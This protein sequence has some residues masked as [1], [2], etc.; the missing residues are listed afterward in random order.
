MADLVSGNVMSVKGDLTKPDPYLLAHGIVFI[1]AFSI[2]M[3]VTSYLIL[4]DRERYYVTHNVVGIII[5]VL[6]VIGWGL[7]TGA[8]KGREA[9]KM[10]LPMNDNAVGLSHSPTGIVARYVAVGVCII[11]VILAVVRMPPKV[12]PFVRW[13]H[14]V[15]GVLLSIYGPF[16]V[17]NGWVR[18]A[19]TANSALD[20]TPMIWLSVVIGVVFAYAIGLVLRRMSPP[21]KQQTDSITNEDANGDDIEKSIPSLSLA[22]VLE[23]V[24][25]RE[26]FL[27]NGTEVI[28]LDPEFIHPGG[29]AV[30]AQYIG[31]DISSVF[32]GTEMFEDGDRKRVWSHSTIAMSRLREMRV[33]TIDL[34]D[35]NST[36]GTWNG[37][38]SIDETGGWSKTVGII[39][40]KSVATLATSQHP[41][42]QLRIKVLDILL[43]GL[44]EIGSKIKLSLQYSEDSVERTYTVAEIF[45]ADRIIVLYIKVYPNGVMTPLIA[46]LEDHDSVFISGLVSPTKLASGNGVVML[47][48]GTGIVPMLSYLLSSDSGCL[49]WWLSD[50]GDVFLVDVLKSYLI[51]KSVR[52]K[53]FF[54]CIQQREELIMDQVPDWIVGEGRI[55]EDALRSAIGDLDVSMVVMSGPPGF[56]KAGSAAVSAVGLSDKFL[57]L[58]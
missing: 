47:A 1:I 41:V 35:G 9:G 16:V 38:F 43:F 19:V 37:N 45:D 36:T 17:W 40:G 58:D 49:L 46:A 42:I 3:P 31:K 4:W 30:M 51:G 48:A 34:G 57:C 15:V 10:Y 53:I 21:V 20:T 24:R 11:G 5:T 28:M 33:C 32:G 27:Y 39:V 6:L 54:T 7:L 22:Q 26:Y 25:D 12:R 8:V 52:M 18:M 29:T 56:I 44:I 2:L 13:S 14:G 50:V 23:L 55:C